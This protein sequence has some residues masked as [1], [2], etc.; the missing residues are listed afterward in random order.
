MKEKFIENNIEYILAEDGI[1]Y[2][3]LKLLEDNETRPIDL[4]DSL[5]RTYLKDHRPALF[6][7]FQLSG[8]LTK[9][10]ADTNESALER[11][12]IIIKQMAEQQ[13]INEQLKS[14]NWLKWVQFMNN[15]YNAAQEM[16]FTELIYL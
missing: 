12:E 5:R 15:I 9:H 2:P 1:Y 7:Y 14:S 4:Y 3:N 11:I 6:I 16:V 13:G 8:T 10:L